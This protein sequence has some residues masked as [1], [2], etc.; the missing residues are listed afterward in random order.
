MAFV[1]GAAP[2]GTAQSTDR[3]LVVGTVTDATG[4]V[5]HGAAVHLSVAGDAPEAPA[6]GARHRTAPG[7]FA[8]AANAGRYVLTVEAPGFAAY[9]SKPLDLKPHSRVQLPVRLAVASLQQEIDVLDESG[10][11]PGGAAGEIVFEGDTLNLLRTTPSP[12]NSN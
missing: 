2:G 7:E 4:A 9:R 3:A 5:I 6:T 12:C 1:S 8:I 11:T 10:L